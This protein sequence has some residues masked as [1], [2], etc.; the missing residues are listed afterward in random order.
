MLP[1]IHLD[2]ENFDDILEN[3]K[4]MI[5]SI[6]PEWTDFNYHDPGVTLLELFA[7]FKESQ[8]YY[9]NKIGPE[10]YKKYLK[11][12]GIE[13]QTKKP[14]CTDV[15]VRY[16]DDIIAA[17]GTKLYAGSICFEADDR[18][19]ISSSEICCCIC[20]NNSDLRII[21][22]N[23]LSFG[24]N[25]RIFPFSADNSGVFYVG[26]DKPLKEKEKHSIYFKISDGN[27]PKRNAINSRD[28][29]IPL[30]DVVIECFDGS[31]WSTALSR[32]DTYGFITSGKVEF[33]FDKEHKSCSVGEKEA[34]YI[35]FR[36]V[37][38]EYDIP[39]LIKD[40]EFNL[41]PVTQRETKA[42]FFDFDVSDS[43]SL[44]TELAVLGD[45]KVFLKGT[46]GLFTPISQFSKVINE[47]N[48]EVTYTVPDC[49]G[50]A[51]IR[52]VNI[53]NDFYLESAVGFGTGLPYQKYNLETFKLE[54]ESFA[55]MSELPDSGGKYVEWNKV[56]DFSSS[57]PED[58]VYVLNSDEGTIEFGDCIRGMAPEGKIFIIG[59]SITEA[60]DGN[61]TKGKICRMAEFD[62]AEISIS[63]SRSSKG[64]KDEETLE[65]CCIRAHKLLETTDTL[66]TGR[67][68]EEFIAS[69]QG[70]KIDKCKVI[71]MKNDLDKGN[72][73]EISV[74]VKP[75]S[76][77][78]KGIPNERYIKNIMTA[79]ESRR[80][81]G[82]QFRIVKPEYLGVGI[83]ADVRVSRDCYDAR[84]I[85]YNTVKDYFSAFKDDFGVEIIYS[86]LYEI[87]DRLECVISVNTLTLETNGN[88]AQRTREGDLKFSP[89]VLAYLSEADTMV[90]VEY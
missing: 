42:E 5:V 71:R 59:Y 22:K 76:A 9:L 81:L 58:F 30:A 8:Q 49:D 41:L 65:N 36:V 46:D 39:P 55:I 19:Y 26:F 43:C 10:N 24:G 56:R 88:G 61:V 2:N 50:A 68:C 31:E 67:D 23:E 77:D 33:S 74:V 16:A 80:M 40:I 62:S 69:V 44:F 35:R 90:N 28:T 18:T 45:S 29:F 14:S 17:K 63:N 25:L 37:S 82:S 84:K 12:I 20:E 7:W 78:G 51:A 83:Y 60:S 86:K 48:G 52:I 53:L 70:L 27:G 79:V 66:V 11:L 21:E 54:Y 34:F 89:N 47:E 85:I 6:Y 72:G 3:A 57:T 64:G 73:M 75:Y 32:D 13:R 87:I 38:G 4:N 1:D 15:T